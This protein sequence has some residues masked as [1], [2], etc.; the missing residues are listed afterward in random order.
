MLESNL[1]GNAEMTLV[2]VVE[3]SNVAQVIAVLSARDVQDV[4]SHFH[5]AQRG[6]GWTLRG[7]SY[8]ASDSDLCSLVEFFAASK[9][10]HW[11]D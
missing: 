7:T 8:R 6:G 10:G 4:R 3:E 11:N 2:P 5:R 9:L 1:I